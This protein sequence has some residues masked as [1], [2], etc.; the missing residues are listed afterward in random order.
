ML[1]DI[2]VVANPNAHKG[3]S[4]KSFEYIKNYFESR[5]R[6]LEFFMTAKAND[7]VE[8]ARRAALEGA[9]IVIAAGGDGTVNECCDGMMRA[10]TDTPLGI[11]PVGRGNDFA[12]AAGIPVRLEAS[13]ALVL[14]GKAKATDVGFV[15]GGEYPEGRYFLNGVGAGFEPSV[16]FKASSYKHLNGMP[17][18]VAA[19]FYTLIHTPKPIE[20]TITF[21]GKERVVN[22][23]QISICNGRRMGSAFIMAPNGVIDDGKIDLVFANAPITGGELLCYAFDFFRGTQ[24]R[25]KKFEE[26]KVRNVTLSA[27]SPFPL[28]ADGEVVSYGANRCSV[29]LLPGALKIYRW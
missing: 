22:T 15:K 10:G 5:S 23:Q 12:F 6:K 3:K 29:E 11:I 7:A 20:T 1:H 27:Q 16:N 18:Y 9:N 28:H 14:N 17:S 4:R 13:C 21:D 26:F 8:L 19:F 25:R 24:L 2:V